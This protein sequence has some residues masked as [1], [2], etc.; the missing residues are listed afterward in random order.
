MVLRKT[1]KGQET[2]S[3]FLTGGETHLVSCPCLAIVV[4][5][6]LRH[7]LLAV[8]RLGSTPARE[9]RR[10]VLLFI[11]TLLNSLLGRT[12]DQVHVLSFVL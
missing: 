1:D 6:V 12:L 8:S 9:R 11:Q 5:R 2:K 3:L 7:G 4:Y 10:N